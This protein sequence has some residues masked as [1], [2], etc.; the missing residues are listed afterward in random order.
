MELG[1]GEKVIKKPGSYSVG[2]IDEWEELR[3]LD[4]SKKEGRKG[5]IK[6]TIEQANMFM[7]RLYG[8]QPL[9]T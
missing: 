8:S 6:Y 9:L 3:H 4:K 7:Y 5:K 2:P 1:P